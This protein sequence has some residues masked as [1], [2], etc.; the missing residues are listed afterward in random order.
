MRE[1][2]ILWPVCWA[3]LVVTVLVVVFSIPV[4]AKSHPDRF[5]A[6]EL[7]TLTGD[8][9]DFERRLDGKKAIVAFWRMGQVR[10]TELLHDLESLKREFAADGLVVV[11]IVSGES[12]SDAIRRLAT[13]TGVSFPMLLDPD[14]HVRRAMEVIVT[15]TSFFVD[16]RKV[17]FVLPGH[18]ADFMPTARADVEATLGRISGQERAA[19]LAKPQQQLAKT[20]PGIGESADSGETGGPTY[21]LARR[22]LAK[23]EREAAKDHFRKAWDA[24]PRVPGAGVDLALLLLED[25]QTSEALAL[26]EQVMEL[27]KDDPRALGV[28]GLAQLRSGKVEAGAAKLLRA[29]KGGAAEPIFFWELGRHSEAAGRTEEALDHYRTGFRALLDREAAREALHR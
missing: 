6:F 7:P 18:F 15:P 23:G 24:S 4:E 5:G 8:T 10:S 12:D 11:A 16:S 14:Q 20:K 13:D 17:R 28:D 19:R 21:N 2:G 29:L 25:D 27:L 9:F 22:L 26:I 3:G 1:T